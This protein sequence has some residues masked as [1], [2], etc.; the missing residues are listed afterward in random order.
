MPTTS[1][2]SHVSRSG[3]RSAAG[4]RMRRV[5][6]SPAGAGRPRRRRRRA[7]AV[8]LFSL[9]L[10]GIG[11]AADGFLR[12]AGE[13]S[14]MSIPASTDA[15]AI[16]VL[17]GGSDRISGGMALLREGHGRRLLIS[18]VHPETSAA[19]IAR[20]TATG[21]SILDCCVDLDR[22]AANTIG[23]AVE[24]ARW[25]SQHGFNSLI[26]VTSAYHMPRSMMELGHAMPDR[27]LIP[28]PISPSRMELG[29]WY[30]RS[31]TALLLLTE[32]VKYTAA[33]VRLLMTPE[34]MI[35]M[36]AADAVG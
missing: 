4:R 16:V 23:N 5:A 36:L 17:T 29:D 1:P 18:G 7:L 33:R 8:V 27:Q 22:R 24:T 2:T 3:G 12:F 26:V 19:Q 31:D 11:F 30:V 34:R 15:D 13:V 28:Y 9:L 20:V 32:Y 14:A 25:A 35:P 6:T 10:A 21:P